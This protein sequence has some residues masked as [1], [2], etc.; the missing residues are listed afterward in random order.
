MFVPRPALEESLHQALA[1]DGRPVAVTGPPGSG[2]ST[3]TRRALASLEEPVILVAA[4]SVTTVTELISAVGTAIGATLLELEPV[5]RSLAGRGDCTL[6]LDDADR[7]VETLP[8]F[9][10]HLANRAPLVRLVTT[11][12]RRVP[13]KDAVLLDVGPMSPPE[14][15]DLFE[16]VARRVRPGFVVEPT[17]EPTVTKLLEALDCIPLAIEL[18]AARMGTLGPA[19]LFDRLEQRF[20]VLR[21]EGGSL[22]DALETSWELLDDVER[23][24]MRQLTVFEGSFTAEAVEA[25]VEVADE[26]ILDVVERLTSRSMLR[27]QPQPDGGMR[28]VLLESIREF[29]GRVGAPGSATIE[30]HARYTLERCRTLTW[31]MRRPGGES[32]RAELEAELPNL[33][34][35]LRRAADPETIAECALVLDKAFRLRAAPRQWAEVLERA[36]SLDGLGPGTKARIARARGELDASR[37]ELDGATRHLE[38]AREHA[39]DAGERTT[40]AWTLFLLGEVERRR[41]RPEAAETHLRATLEE[42]AE[43]ESTELERMALGHLAGALVDRGDLGAARAAIEKMNRTPPSDDLRDEARLLK[44]VAYAQYYLGNYDEQQRLNEAA[45]GFAHEAGDERMVALA[46]QGLGDVA[47]V[48]GDHAA[49]RAYWQEALAMHRQHGSIELEAALLGNLGSMEHRLGNLVAARRAIRAALELHSGAGATPYEAVAL[50]GLGVLE[51]EQGHLQDALG[52]LER[53]AGLNRS[54]GNDADLGGAL[55]VTAWTLHAAGRDPS[56]ALDRARQAFLAAGD[57]EWAALCTLPA[58]DPDRFTDSTVRECARALHG[59]ASVDTQKLHVRAAA[60]SVSAGG[61]EEEAPALIVEGTGAWFENASGRVDLGRR[62]APRRILA[63]LAEL[64]EEEPGAALDV[65]GMFEVGWPDEVAAP[66]AA[67]DRV[68]WAVRTLRKLGL[69]ELITSGDGY[70]LDPKVGFAC[71]PP[72]G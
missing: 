5:M 51:L 26:W 60:A 56:D 46:T 10:E 38:R 43:L 14:A 53:C 63:R 69:E 21:G 36:A 67:S 41:G 2:K 39:I 42:A 15:R 49:A 13:S 8:E 4:S 18:A 66:E 7:V 58:P 24:T 30:S 64:R 65:Y 44:R 27:Q 11:S 50:F 1:R 34:G 37:G 19:Q 62:R 55:L 33:M 9:E 52:A 59:M 20:K 28:F 71:T 47:F 40:A 3:L 70:L 23:E 45:L 29:V 68:Y 35:A 22:A 72:P 6:L 61:V 16:Q 54:I 25:V 48:R 31:Q 17:V 57:E 32:A 12:R